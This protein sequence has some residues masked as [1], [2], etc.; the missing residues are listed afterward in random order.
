MAKN[1]LEL[2]AEQKGSIGEW[3]VV[4]GLHA[5]TVAGE[6]EGLGL[7]IPEGEREHPAEPIDASLAPLLPAV[8]DHL[9]IAPG[10]ED[11][12]Q[13]GQLVHERLKVVDLAVVS[14]DD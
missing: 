7:S 12:P 5:Q 13:G 10:A 4:E 8:D 11:V 1:R 2:R 3:G 14:D 6:K 9:G